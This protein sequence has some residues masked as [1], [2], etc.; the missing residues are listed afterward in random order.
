MSLT[1]SFQ[2]AVSGMNAARAGL[3]VV[4]HNL[5]NQETP[6]YVRQQTLQSFFYPQNIGANASGKLQVGLGTDIAAIRQIRDKYLDQAYR[7]EASAYGFY[8]AKY[9][10]AV[11]IDYILGELESEY[12]LGD[13]L[14]DIY[15]ALNELSINPSALETRAN[16]IETCVTF[17]SK[18]NDIYDRLLSYQENLNDKIKDDVRQ[19]NDLVA[20]VNALNPK[21]AMA[22][23]S[24]D[25]A[26]DYRDARNLAIDK[27][28]ALIG[29]IVKERPNGYVE[30]QTESGAP[31][32]S[33]GAVNRIGLRYSSPNLDFVEPVFTESDTILPYDPTNKN[34]DPLFDFSR[35]VNGD[36]GE[37]KGLIIAR[38]YAPHNYAMA[39][40]TLDENDP[41]EAKLAWSARNCQI[42]QV[43]IALDTLVRSVCVMI[44]NAVAPYDPATGEKDAANA[45]YGLDGSQFTEVFSRKYVSRWNGD[46]YNPETASDPYSLYSIGNITVN[47]AILGVADYDKIPLSYSGDQGDQSALLD[48][49]EKWKT[50]WEDGAGNKFT[51]LNGEEPVSVGQFYRQMITAAGSEGAQ[52]KSMAESGQIVLN[53]LDNRRL[54]VSGVSAD[55]EMTNMLTYQHAYNASARLLNV[56][57]SMM[58]KLVNGTGRV[59]L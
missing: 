52:A 39:A 32:L 29:V 15:S 21:I 46:D 40:G 54:A 4:G 59:G 22:E 28:S 18:T 35:G 6:G 34:A 42:P 27:L 8:S 2:S 14:D 51:A 1:A 33:G 43:Q 53:Q 41:A 11:E 56:L 3:Y 19:I 16:F 44:N 12:K 36:T 26:N 9:S 49:I 58:D 24:G 30:L 38:G 31:L 50:G 23:A 45:P 57:D 17:V 37:L 25:N 13:V 20:E 7:E 5:A 48:L 55:E 10:A 47:P